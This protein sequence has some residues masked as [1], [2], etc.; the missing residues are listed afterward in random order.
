MIYKYNVWTLLTAVVLGVKAYFFRAIFHDWLDSSCR[1]ILRN[2]AAAMK[3]GYS[4]PLIDDAVLPDFGV[5]RYEAF[6][7]LTMMALETGAERSSKQ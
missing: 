7:D 3:K 4:K 2:T 1:E 5:S 6:S